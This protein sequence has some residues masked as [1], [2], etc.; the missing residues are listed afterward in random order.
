MQTIRQFREL[1]RLFF[2]RFLEN[3]LICLD[4]DTRGTLVGVLALLAAPGLFIPF[5][6]LLQFSSWPLSVAAWQDRD[7]VALP[8]KVLHLGLS[9]TVLGIVTVLEWDAILPDRRDFAVLRP[10]PISL[11]T[12]FAAKVAALLQ[13]W[14]VFTAVI[15]ALPSVLFPFAVLQRGDLSVLLNFIRSHVVAV[16]ACNGFVF[17]A[18][19]TVQGVLLNA[20]GW[21]NYRRLAPYLQTCLIAVL[22][23]MFFLSMGIAFQLD[24]GSPNEPIFSALPAVWFLGLYQV[25]LGWSNPIFQALAGRAVAALLIATVVATVTYAMSYR[26]S[27]TMQFEQADLPRAKP[28]RCRTLATRLLHRWFLPTTAERASFHFVCQTIARSR[29]HRVLVAGYAGVGFALVFQS[30]VGVIAGGHP[31]WWR[32]AAGPLMPAPVVLSLFLLA[33]LRYAYTV[34]AELRANWIFQLAGSAKPEELL[35]GVRKATAVITVLPL[36]V[37]PLPLHVALWGWSISLVH[38][39]FGG[40]V[41]FLLMEVVLLS[42]GKM[43]FTCS[44]VPGKANLKATWPVYV[45]L[46]LGYV[47]LC[48]WVEILILSDRMRLAWFVA[49]AAVCH[50][51]LSTWR[52]RLLQDDFALLYDEV[53]EPV[54][55]TLGLQQ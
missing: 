14:A 26:R 49:A 47:A 29:G 44:Y 33:G 41:S 27:V 54:V 5:F 35:R 46:Y 21:R 30:L 12:M 23:G 22:L 15:S 6:E 50:A 28:G 37:L 36:F 24:P 20:L 16:L 32:H 11:R 8:N 40:V 53:P 2:E 34:P 13:F 3:D 51:A 17:L 52:R 55:R 31:D 9:M 4:G 1:T 45:L 43:P 19:I 18:M 7:L 48:T 25:Q 39:V 10:L 38:T 42:L